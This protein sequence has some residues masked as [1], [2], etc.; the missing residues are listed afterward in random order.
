MPPARPPRRSVQLCRALGLGVAAL[1]AAGACGGG[2][3]APANSAAAP[4]SAAPPRLGA[5]PVLSGTARLVFPL[6][7]YDG[8]PSDQPLLER[9]QDELAVRC[10]ARYGFTYVPPE[11]NARAPR[12]ANARVFGVVDP[13][14]AAVYGYR[15]PGAA[16]GDR[17]APVGVELSE[18][19]RLTLYGERVDPAEMPM[20]QEEAEREGGSGR[21]AGG[22]AVP[23]GGCNRES[24]LKLYAPTADSVDI[25]FVFN[26]KA[27]AKAQSE[28]DARVVRNDAEWAA[29]M[30]AA[31]YED[32]ADP[33]RAVQQLGLQ[34]DPSG[35][36]AIA[37]AKADVACKQKVNLVGV[38]YTVQ[39][40]YQKR[41]VAEHAAT[42]EL[43]GKQQ[44]DRLKR[45]A[46][47]TR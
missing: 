14:E 3:E 47:L 37:A 36:A 18:E 6:D 33:M 4:G 15:D 41:L 5:V 46:A 42:L 16:A 21:K 44:E 32:A 29:C 26:L 28:A 2:E 35:P 30:K 9:A 25:M 20:S 11:R 17:R 1:L 40:A 12:P 39:S 19:G 45:A 24:F 7:A 38:R 43:A 10:M 34:D 13:R 8:R 31:G 27:R 23:V 22:R